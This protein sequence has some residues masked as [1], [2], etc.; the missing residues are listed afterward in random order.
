VKGRDKMRKQ[1]PKISRRKASN[2]IAKG[3]EP[4]RRDFIKHSALLVGVSAMPLGILS[5]SSRKALAQTV[6]TFDYYISLTGN[7]SNPGTLTSPWA[8]T[9]LRAMSANWSKLSGKRI[10]LLTGTY[11]VGSM[12]VDD[13]A[14]GAL[15]IPGGTSSSWTYLVS[16]NT[17]G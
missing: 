6:T 4:S 11:N 2:I 16:S 7:D 1:K 5:L 15:Q 13:P 10:G 17:S 8:L 14:T 3:F 9:S 12:M